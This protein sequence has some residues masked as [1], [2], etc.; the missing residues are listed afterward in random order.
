MGTHATA[1]LWRSEDNVVEPVPSAHLSG[2]PG[3]EFRTLGMCG[4][5]LYP[6]SQL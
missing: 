3:T 5:H 6:L 4:K 2:V 1:C